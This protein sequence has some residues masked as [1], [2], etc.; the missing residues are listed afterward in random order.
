MR[1]WRVCRNWHDLKSIAR[2]KPPFGGY[3]SQEDTFAHFDR[4]RRQELFLDLAP[5]HADIIG[6]QIRDGF[7]PGEE[8]VAIVN[9]L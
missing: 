8:A 3:S 6:T 9:Q 2:A 7:R 5:D 1:S 4:P